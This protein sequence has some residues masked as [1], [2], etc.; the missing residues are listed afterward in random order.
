MT[1]TTTA[2]TTIQ[3]G[4]RVDHLPAVSIGLPVYNGGKYLREALDS[5]LVQTFTDFELI[6]SDNASTDETQGICEEYARLDRRIRYVRQP[7]WISAF[8]NFQ[9]CLNEGQGKYFMWAAVDDYHPSNFIEQLVSCLEKNPKAVLASGKIQV[10]KG[11]LSV[12]TAADIAVPFSTEGVN[13]FTRL[14]ITSQLQCFHI[15]GLWKADAI[16]AIPRIYCNWWADLA[17][18]MSGSVLGEF[19]CCRDTAF[20]HRE[21][22]KTNLERAKYQDGCV[23]HSRIRSLLNLLRVTFLSV[24]KTGGGLLATYAVSLVLVKQVRELPQFIKN[25]ILFYKKS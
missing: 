15:Y 13:V 10:I 17:I 9:Y 11:D 14:L 6:V 24:K 23:G 2:T 25:R 18:L 5:L 19:I 8:D 20:G 3:Q 16:K 22:V 7:K 21:I 1:D 12:S 4:R